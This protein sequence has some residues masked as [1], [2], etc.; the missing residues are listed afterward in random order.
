[1]VNYQQIKKSPGKCSNLLSILMEGSSAG[2][3]GV[4]ANIVIPKMFPY[5]AHL[6]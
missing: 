3:A 2:I 4:H 6:R 5:P 1:M